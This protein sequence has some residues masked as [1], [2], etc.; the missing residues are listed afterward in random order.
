ME[1]LEYRG[2]VDKTA[3]PRGP[4]DDEPD[5]V[6]WRDDETGLP[7]LIVRNRR[8]ALTGYVG[9]PVGHPWHGLRYECGGSIRGGGKNPNPPKVHGGLTFGGDCSHGAPERS[10]CHIPA[11]GEPDDVWW[12]G[13]DCAHPGDMVLADA[14]TGVYR[15][16]G[17]VRGEVCGLARQA[18]R[19]T[20]RA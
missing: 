14:Q 16:L 4:W 2:V 1:T 15:D 8:G 19:A 10:V 17:Y 12:L 18:S 20:A 5:K 9:V 7:C 11:P 6:Q 3:W 13:F